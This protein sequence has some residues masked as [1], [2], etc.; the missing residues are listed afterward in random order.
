MAG[1]KTKVK[2]LTAVRSHTSRLEWFALRVQ[3]RREEN[4][5]ESLRKGNG[6]GGPKDLSP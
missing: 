1:R 6:N 4:V 5:A 2:S 3:P